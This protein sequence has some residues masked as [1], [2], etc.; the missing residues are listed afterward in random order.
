MHSIVD[1]ILI[2]FCLIPKVNLGLE[3]WDLCFVEKWDLCFVIY[4]FLL[5]NPS[6]GDINLMNLPSSCS[7]LVLPGDTC[8]SRN[9]SL[10]LSIALICTS[11]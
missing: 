9:S 3:N 8:K 6:L 1:M 10:T 5:N 2:V 4:T 11:K 7:T